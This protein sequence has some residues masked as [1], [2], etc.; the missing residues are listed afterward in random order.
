MQFKTETCQIVWQLV[1]LLILEV[2]VYYIQVRRMTCITSVWVCIN[3]QRQIK[4]IQIWK[5][6]R[7]NR[8]LYRNMYCNNIDLN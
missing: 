1:L 6:N 8:I 7:N 3:V 5:I 4:C 2:Y